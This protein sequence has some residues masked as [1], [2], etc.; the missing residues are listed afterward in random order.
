M[1]FMTFIYLVSKN[2][3]GSTKN[4]WLMKKI[5]DEQIIERIR[6]GGTEANNALKTLMRAW[7]KKSI[8]EGKKYG[9]NKEEIKDPYQESMI[10]L[11][12]NILAR[13][14]RGESKLET[15]WKN[16]FYRK[17]VDWLRKNKTSNNEEFKEHILE[18]PS[19]FKYVYQIAFDEERKIALRKIVGDCLSK[20]KNDCRELILGTYFKGLENIELALIY[21]YSSVGV[22]KTTKYRC[23]VKLKKCSRIKAK[24]YNLF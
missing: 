2:R 10:A 6:T 22:V 15:Y 19:Q 9:L 24:A 20:L 14:F 1:I 3:G 5:D 18:S 8:I 16:I 23:M 13:K 17:C 21:K 4:E 11:Y 7:R 12:E